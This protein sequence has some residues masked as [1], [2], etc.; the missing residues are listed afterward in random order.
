MGILSIPLAECWEEQPFVTP[1]APIWTRPGYHYWLFCHLGLSKICAF[2]VQY[3]TVPK[4]Y[5]RVRLVFHANHTESQVLRVVSAVCEWADEMIDI[6]RS[7]DSVE[8]VPQAA[9]KVYKSMTEK[10]AKL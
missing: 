8:K 7:D 10:H 2:A 3:P 5:P 1:V 6:E 4:E 9:R